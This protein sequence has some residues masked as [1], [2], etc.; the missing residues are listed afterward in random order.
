M[1]RNSSKNRF[2]TMIVV[3]LM[4]HYYLCDI[5]AQPKYD[6]V[7]VTASNPDPLPGTEGNIISFDEGV[8]TVS[9][10]MLTQ[11]IRGNNASICD[12]D[13]NL[14]MYTN[15]CNILDAS[16][17]VM[18]GGGMINP[19]E[20]WDNNCL[21]GGE[22]PSSQ[23]VIFLPDRYVDNIYYLLHKPL[24]FIQE[25]QGNDF[26]R[27]ELFIT[28][29]DISLNDG[30]GSVISKNIQVDSSYNYSGGYGEAISHSNQLDWWY[31]DVEEGSNLITKYL[32][33]NNG[34]TLV[35]TQSIGAVLVDDLCSIGG[36]S[37]FSPDGT[38][39]SKMCPLSGLDVMEF[40]RETGELSNNRHVWI[41]T[42]YQVCGLSFSPNSQ[43]IYVSTTDSLWQVDVR[44]EN[45]EDGLVFID[46]YDGFLDPFRT[47]IVKQQ[48]GPDCRIY[49]SSNNGVSSMH[50]IRNPDAKGTD[51]DFRQHHLDLPYNNGILSMPNFPHFRVDEDD[52]CDQTITSVFGVQV[53]TVSN[54][55]VFPNP[56]SGIVTVE[57]AEISDGRI[58]ISNVTGQ[59]VMTREFGYADVIELDLSF[60]DTGMYFIEVV[61]H[62]GSRAVEKVVRL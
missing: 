13:G 45:L 57:L 16:H 49:I 48:L 41:P 51:C 47:T 14:L 42:D 8:V 26:R 9:Y 34:M 29:I 37:C 40:D 23:D 35:D 31:L 44:E 6:Y 20:I 28:T 3:C 12:V 43:F 21:S 52:V 61:Y 1:L 4:A 53:E 50:V 60:Y 62:D 10:E 25:S 18:D 58:L 2:L 7:W 15:G 24:K 54:M 36:Q 56:T 33:D 27:S 17:Q 32:L 39:Y 55:E 38:L 11:N 59:V 46:E 19:G 5:Q 30:L 22:Y